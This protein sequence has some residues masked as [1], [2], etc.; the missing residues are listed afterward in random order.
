MAEQVSGGQPEWY[1]AFVQWWQQNVKTEADAR[2]G[3]AYFQQLLQRDEQ[4]IAEAKQ[5]DKQEKA[6]SRQDMTA[7]AGLGAIAVMPA[8]QEGISG[9]EIGSGVKGLLGLGGASTPATPSI[10]SASRVGDVA[11]LSGG[12]GIG[13]GGGGGA[14]ASGGAAGAPMTVGPMMGAA[15][16]AAT[17]L[18]A[19]HVVEPMLQ[20]AFGRDKPGRVYDR[21]AIL[22]ANL[23]NP[24]R[25]KQME[26]SI[27]GFSAASR[28]TQ[29]RILDF[30]NEKNLLNLIGNAEEELGENYEN[31]SWNRQQRPGWT[32]SRE[33]LKK[34]QQRETED[35][36]YNSRMPDIASIQANKGMSKERKDKLIGTINELQ[37]LF[38]IGAPAPGATPPPPPPAAPA[39]EFKTLEGNAGQM[40]SDAFAKL[41]SGGLQS[42]VA[43]PVSGTPGLS[44]APLDLNKLT[45]DQQALYQ[46]LQSQGLLR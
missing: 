42:P 3:N 33:E 12:G 1:P 5:E 6:E 13:G 18:I 20:K 8:L 35:R 29:G 10:V 22:E 24:E 31:V 7:L 26:N 46:Q 44:S 41:G 30:L 34:N 40:S 9:A 15:G 21:E 28:E 25:M 4:R 39:S 23:A 36:G 19:K 16:L 27:P 14:V 45:P 38:A 11:G 32:L 2:A 37:G 43:T 17:P